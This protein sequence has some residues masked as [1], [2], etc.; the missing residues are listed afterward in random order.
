MNAANLNEY[1]QLFH[2]DMRSCQRRI[3]FAA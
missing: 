3:I 2:T 1:S